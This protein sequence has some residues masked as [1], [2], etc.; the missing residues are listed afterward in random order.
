MKKLNV[1]NF[2]LFLTV[3]F[4][5]KNE[6]SNLFP[7]IEKKYWTPD[8]YTNANAEILSLRS[9][10]KE[11]PNLDDPKTAPLF[12]KIIDTNNFSVVASD[13]QLGLE[14]RKEFLNKM[15]D[16]YRQ[17]PDEY[18]EA[19]R[20]DKYK[21][22]LELVEIEKFG[23]A[24]QIPYIETGNQSIIKNADNPNAQEIIDITTKNR[25]ILIRNYTLYL[26]HINHEE[27]FTDR[28][29]TSYSEGIKDFFPRLINDVAPT[30][31]YSGLL[32]K[33]DNM[34]K[35]SK[36]GLIIAQLQNIQTLLKSKSPV[37]Q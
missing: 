28:A 30:G 4:S 1:V 8:D 33:I 12:K 19:D 14:H 10:N 2:L 21:Y 29:L 7:P 15:F 32:E 25:N 9:N 17:L 5:C 31:D 36:N 26:E 35:K 18:N 11:L 34:L 37:T 13:D 27:R 16:Q 6:D 22:P 3:F 23:L 20:S 24:L